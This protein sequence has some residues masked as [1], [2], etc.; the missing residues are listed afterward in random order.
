[1]VEVNQCGLMLVT[2]G[3]VESETHTNCI[4]NTESNMEYSLYFCLMSKLN[5]YHVLSLSFSK[6]ILGL[7]AMLT[8]NLHMSM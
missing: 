2:R 3:D 1:M 7:E 8:W 6:S 5:L 4:Y